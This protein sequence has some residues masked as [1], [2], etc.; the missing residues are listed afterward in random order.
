M[1]IGNAAAGN[2]LMKIAQRS[3]FKRWPKQESAATK[4][5]VRF[6]TALLASKTLKIFIF[7]QKRVNFTCQ[8]KST[9]ER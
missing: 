5:S 1:D 3:T 6:K 9:S 2:E 8:L 7:P 4:L